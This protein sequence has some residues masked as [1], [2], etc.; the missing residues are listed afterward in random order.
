MAMKIIWFLIGL[1]ILTC[2]Y[3]YIGYLVAEARFKYELKKNKE[4]IDNLNDYVRFLQIEL[5]AE[6]RKNINV[7]ISEPKEETVV[8]D[9][10]F[11]D[12][13]EIG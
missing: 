2:F 8:R 13:K 3:T 11:E 5:I 12:F 1:M 4:T 9:P 10:H 6:R 7:T